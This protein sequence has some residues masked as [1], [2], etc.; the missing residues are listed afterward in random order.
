MHYVKPWFEGSTSS[1]SETSSSPASAPTPAKRASK[2]D[3]ITLRIC[4]AIQAFLYV[5]LALNVSATVFVVLSV[6]LTLGSASNPLFNSFI[7]ALLPTSHEAGRLFG[8]ISVI[9]SIGSSLISPV[10]FGNLYAY[11]VGFYA[12]SFFAL[13]AVMVFI[14]LLFVMLIRLP[15]EAGVNV[16]ERGRSRNVKRVKSSGAEGGIRGDASSRGK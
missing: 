4:I 15:E 12:P 6:F 2:L 16:A 1:K 5:G 3:L 8:A 11:T 13:G 14:A 7:L 9:D 10:I